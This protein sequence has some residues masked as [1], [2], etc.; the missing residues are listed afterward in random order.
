MRFLLLFVALA[1]LTGC[2][3]FNQ[4]DSCTLVLHFYSEGGVE[5]KAVE[6]ALPGDKTILPSASLQINE[7]HLTGTGPGEETLNVT[8]GESQ[9]S[10]AVVPGEWSFYVQGFNPEGILVAEGYATIFLYPGDKR[11]LEILLLPLLGTGRLLGTI[12]WPL[13]LPPDTSLTISLTPLFS[14]EEQQ[15]FQVPPPET[16]LEITSLSAGYHN[17]SAALSDGTSLF[18]GLREVIRILSGQDTLINLSLSL[19]SASLS[20]TVTQ[21]LYPPLDP[22]LIPWELAGV[23]G[24]PVKLKTLVENAQ[25][26]LEISWYSNSQLVAEGL[27][28]ALWTQNFPSSSRVDVMALCSTSQRAGSTSVLAKEGG[29]H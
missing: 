28:T 21:N 13:G 4:E 16:A 25:G 7:Y 29:K 22:I 11:S 6:P 23:R 15:V 18:S 9:V 26:P 12:Q 3:P 27:E 17:L 20:L 8:T 24:F 10:S 19:E 1:A 14:Q 2:H 5:N